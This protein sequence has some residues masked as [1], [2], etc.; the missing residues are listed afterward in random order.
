[1]SNSITHEKV[2]DQLERHG[3]G[4]LIGIIPALHNQYTLPIMKKLSSMLAEWKL[5]SGSH[6][7]V[8]TGKNN[9]P[10]NNLYFSVHSYKLKL[11]RCNTKK[12]VKAFYERK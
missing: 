3:D 5:Q 9:K 11:Y 4:F 1:M 2:R 7:W 12:E 10:I 6:V 8:Y